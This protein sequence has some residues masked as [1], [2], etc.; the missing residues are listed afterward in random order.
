MKK[1]S[2]IALLILCLLL[3]GCAGWM[4]GSYVSVTPREAQS[5][6]VQSGKVSASNYTQLL[7]VLTQMVDSGAESAVINVADYDQDSLESGLHP[8]I[9]ESGEADAGIEAKIQAR[10]DAKKA[11][12][13]AEADRIRDELKAEGIE[14][15]DI[16]GGVRWKKV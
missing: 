16:P 8:I 15:T 5:S 11:K 1:G 13:F 7:E 2:L 14:I 4:N 3:T 9:S 6:G 10:Q 12:N